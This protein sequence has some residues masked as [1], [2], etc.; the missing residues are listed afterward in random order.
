MSKLYFLLWLLMFS[1]SSGAQN[2]SFDRLSFL[3]GTWEG[4]G[5]GFGNEKSAVHSEFNLVIGDQYIEVFNQSWFEPTVDNQEGE[6]H[7][8]RGYISYDKTRDRLVFRQFHIEG[9]VNT[10]VLVDSLSSADIL[11]FRTESIENFMPGGK[12]QWTIR[13]TDETHIETIFDVSFPGEGY[14]CFGTNRLQK[15]D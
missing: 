6:L 11:V 15:S 12:A 1:V 14:T 10:Y 8:D 5:T 2:H 9:Y 7:V 4:E 13:R 3:L